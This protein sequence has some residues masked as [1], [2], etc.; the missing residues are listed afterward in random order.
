MATDV[1]LWIRAE[2]ERIAE[3]LKNLIKVLVDRADAE[4]DVLM[5]G[6]THL[7]RAQPIRWAHLLLSYAWF[8]RADHHRLQQLLLNE[9]AATQLCP[10]GSGA[11]AGNPFGIDRAQ[12]AAELGFTGGYTPNSLYGVS[13]RDFIA[14]FLYMGTMVCIAID[15][16]LIRYSQCTHRR[17]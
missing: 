16:V 13:D 1:R 4:Q 11:L 17:S 9:Q 10:L 5:P 3:S 6:Y 8:L 15:Y 7:Q 2:A 14:D 12:L